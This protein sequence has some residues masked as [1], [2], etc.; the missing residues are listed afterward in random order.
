MLKYIPL[1][2][3]VDREEVIAQI[4]DAVIDPK[5][6]FNVHKDKIIGRGAYSIVL[7]CSLDDQAFAVKVPSSIR[8][9]KLVLKE[10]FNYRII[11][12]YELLH[13]I[14]QAG[15]P[16]L[17][18]YGLTF[19]DKSHLTRIR[20]HESRPC[21]VS[22]QLSCS[23]EKLISKAA[24]SG[25]LHIGN[26][27]WWRLAHQLMNALQLLRHCHIV[28]MDLKP[29]NVLFDSTYGDFKVC[30]FSSA[31]LEED[32]HAEYERRINDGL[33]YDVTLQYCAPELAQLPPSSPSYHTDLYAV[34]LTLLFAATGEQPYADIL[35]AGS[36]FIY[37]N[38]CIKKN[39]VLDFVSCQGLKKLNS[40][41]K[42]MELIKS[43]VARE[44]WETCL[45]IANA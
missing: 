19:M 41:P 16:V 10:M 3:L 38:E 34:G 27:L 33:F 13:G 1:S 37:L 24:H 26:D 23:L 12:N 11:Q 30:D 32:I 8:A 29:S 6:K 2:S 25:Q 36:S 39:K 43:I 20:P 42:A 28:H 35:S 40:D 17:N 4:D 22:E 5:F 7:E 45:K 18:V 21:L 31:G 44:P 14:D 9:S 15:A